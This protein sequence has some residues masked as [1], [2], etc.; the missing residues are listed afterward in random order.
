MGEKIKYYKK[1]GAE[2]KSLPGVEEWLH[3]ECW[4][5]SGPKTFMGMEIIRAE[6]LYYLALGRLAKG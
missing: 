6:E 1:S 5:G 4:S 2:L 3:I